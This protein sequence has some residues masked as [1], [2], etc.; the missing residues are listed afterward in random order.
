M[1]IHIT[2]HGQGRPLVL[3]HG[4][5]FDSQI[6]TSLLP[7]LEKKYQLHLVD[8]PGF[9]LT[10][11]MSWEAFKL[12]LLE[13]LPK[14]FTLVGW[15]MGGLYATRLAVE[16]PSRI[17]ALVNLASSPKFTRAEEWPGVDQA[18]LSNFSED[19]TRSPLLTLEKFMTWQLSAKTKSLIISSKVPSIEALQAGLSVLIDWDLRQTI[20]RFIKPI[21][22]IFAGLDAILP[23]KM[24]EVMQKTYPQFDY[25]MMK[26]ARHAL[27]LSHTDDFVGILEDFIK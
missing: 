26:K 20:N 18:L 17:S 15:S 3:F 5:G 4:F 16:S 13:R 10:N 6:W 25:V 22:F 14:T 2:I 27:F 8:L 1:T 11:L 24:M 12:A 21:L 7:L 23:A 9:G 19:L